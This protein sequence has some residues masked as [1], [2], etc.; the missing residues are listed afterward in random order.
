MEISVLSIVEPHF[1]S[2]Q[3]TSDLFLEGRTGFGHSSIFSDVQASEVK[4]PLIS[5]LVSTGEGST[6][7]FRPVARSPDSTVPN[8]SGSDRGEGL[9]PIDCSTCVSYMLPE[10]KSSPSASSTS[11]RN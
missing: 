7:A 10:Q 4:N 9:S 2:V 6:A 11:H 1:T 8:L 3:E 5:E